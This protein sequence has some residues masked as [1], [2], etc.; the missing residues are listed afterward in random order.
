MSKI[1]FS[2]L[3]GGREG[4]WAP[5]KWLTVLRLLKKHEHSDPYDS[6]NPLYADLEEA[7]PNETWRSVTGD[8]VFRPLFRDYAHPWTRTDV[9][10]FQ[11]EVSITSLG[12]ALLSGRITYHNLLLEFFLNF[13]SGSTYPFHQ[14]IQVITDFTEPKFTTDQVTQHFELTSDS[15]KRRLRLALTLLEYAQIIAKINGQAGEWV[16]IQLPEFNESSTE[17]QLDDMLEAFKRAAEDSL[18]DLSKNLILTSSSSLA[19]KRFLILTGLSGSGKTKLAQAFS[20]WITPVEEAIDPFFDGS[21]IESTQTTYLVKKSD[22]LA[23]EFWNSSDENEAIKVTLPRGIIEEWADYITANGINQNTPGAELREAIKDASKFSDQL[24]SFKTHLKAAAFALVDARRQH[25]AAKRYEVVSVG[26]DWTGN[27]NILGYPNGLDSTSYITKPALELIIHAQKNEDLPYFLILDEMNLSHV[28]RYFADI[29]SAIESGEKIT[30]HGD[31]D[32]EVAS[33]IPRKIKLPENLFIIGTVNV[34]ETTYMFSPKVLDRAN[35]IEFSMDGEDLNKFLD[36][37]AKPDLDKLAGRGAGYG[38]VFVNESKK[39]VNV[40]EGI[41]TRYK[42]EMKAFFTA[43]QSEGAEYGFRVAHE[44]ARFM[45]FY[46]V[47]GGHDATKDD[48]FDDAF[49]A[50]IVQKFLP[51]LHGSSNK[52]SPLLKSLWDLC[53]TKPTVEKE[54]PAGEETA[55]TPEKQEESKPVEITIEAAKTARY[56]KSANKI[57]RMKKLLDSHGFASFAEA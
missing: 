25:Q 49:D 20:Q 1:S 21:E 28:E 13:Q 57:A 55:E 42:D 33:G 27:E 36:N 54:V 12:Q 18:L 45:H 3:D 29:L 37:P 47:L 4:L 10:K 52:L 24:H 34:D 17:H 53:L 38:S 8:Q 6:D 39:A 5:A 11:G 31:K 15:E 30:L 32:R 56:K 51:K 7:L 23:V 50:V 40:P 9:A 48:W 14:L 26:A 19:S 46:Q 22:S 35:V 43:L 41:A 44:A 2:N 16:K